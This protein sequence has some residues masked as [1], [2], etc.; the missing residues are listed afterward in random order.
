MNPH[1]FC[2]RLG[3]LGVA[4]LSL[5]FPGAGRT[6]ESE[7]LFNGK[8]LDGW[9]GLPEFWSV[10]DGVIVGETTE[11]NPTQGNTFLVW[12]GGEVA[13]FEITCQV[14]FQGNNSGL[15]YR[16]S[17]VDADK[18]VL[19]GYQADLHPKQ[20]Y[21]GMLY[22]EKLGKRGIIAQRGQRVEIGEDGKPKVV[23]EVGDGV[24]LKDWEW[25]TLRVIAVGNRLLH[26]VNGVTTV[27]IT[28]G[29]PEA[30]AKGVIGLQL[31]A[32]PPMRVEF[33]DIRLR[34]LAGD[35]A[36]AVL[37][38][39]I[40]TGKGSGKKAAA[41]NARDA[42]WLAKD[43]ELRWIWD[44]SGG[45]N[46]QELWFRKRF[47]IPAG[48]DVKS[49]RI[50]ATCDN[51]MTLWVNGEKAG[52]SRDWPYPIEIDEDAAAM[53]RPGEN[54]IAIH[55]K[56][57]G[58]TA[59][60]VFKL[61]AKLADGKTISVVSSPDWKMMPSK[62]SEGWEAVGFDDS[63]WNG[64]VVA[65]EKIGG[66]PWGIPNYT[67]QPR[68]G[69]GSGKQSP[70]PPEDIT[71][72]EGFK[73]ELLYTV[74]RDD[75]GSWVALTKLPGGKLIAS[76]QGKAGLYEI[77]L[78]E[79][80]DGPKVTV[81]KIPADVSGAWGM[82]WAFDSLYANINGKTLVRV[83]D[84]DG[85]G[86]LDAVEELPGANGGGEHGNHAV[87]PTADGKRLFV[88]AGNSTN[89]MEIAG[90]RVPTWDE[91][92]LLPRQWDARGHARG[93]LAPGGWVS[94]FDPESKDYE[95]F[96]MGF[97]NQY[98]I[99]LNRNGDLFTYDADMEWD[100]GMPWYRPT[101]ICH[102]VSGADFGW[103]S[104]SGK[105]PSYYEDS[106]P[107]VVDI[108]PG[109]PTGVV[110]G[111][112]A[113][114]PSK[115]RDAI[116]ALDWTFGTIYAIHLE[117]QGAGYTGKAEPFVYGAPL[118]VTD[119]IVGDDGALYFTI[120]GRNTQSALYRVT[121]AGEKPG[122]KA[123]AGDP[124]AAK[125]RA[126]RAELEQFHGKVAD[127]AVEKAWPFLS[128]DDRF[129][130][131]AARIAIESQPVEAWADRVFGESDSQARITGAVALARTGDPGKHRAKLLASLL[132]L[133]PDSLTEPQLLGLLRAYALNFIRLGKPTVAERERVIA[134]LD[135]L[136]PQAN[137]DVNTELVRVLVYLESPS[138]IGK[139]MDLIVNR[140]APEVPDW[141]ELASRNPGYGGKIQEM[142]QN[143][144]PSREI[145]Y[146][147]LLRNLKNGWSLKQRRDYFQFLNEAA[148]HTGGASYAG[149]LTN[150]RDEAL[151]NCTNAERAALA[152]VTGENFNPVPDF[153]IAPPKGPGRNWT[154]EDAA[155]HVNSGELKRASF[156]DGRSL[157]H[158]IGCAAC[159][160]F[161]GLGGDIGPDLTSVPN[162]FDANYVLE[163][164]IKPSEVISDQYG[165]SSVTMKN[166]DSHL[167][168]V[169]EREDTVDIY[170]PVNG[171][172]P[173]TVKA[174]DVAKIEESPVSQMPPGLINLL[175]GD[176]VRDLIAYL[177]S[178]GDPDAK[179]YGN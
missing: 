164:I 130:R 142:L 151:G 59:A 158:A 161:D 103:R 25:N 68:S 108:G 38:K 75:E 20:E 33:K 32:G 95:L 131:H 26:Q 132:E 17:I 40:A 116:F 174:A 18:F 79:S 92:L 170:P 172:E 43:G 13:D 148:K 149:F 125:A 93:R 168:L 102:V 159:H 96:A 89:L 139:T 27:D 10:T 91:D 118:P 104:G 143:H 60:L 5:A 178:G 109:S 100:M 101:R 120:G 106:L 111:I 19:A 138:V 44:E 141:T 63:A 58:G 146:A 51:Q 16:S 166:G 169:I 78:A 45:K 98:D 136:L 110:A 122:E 21:F 8:N 113:K 30:L 133:D 7:P 54:V 39:A 127:G 83:R 117:E 37:E 1:R 160:R 87:I 119:A 69:G 77:S 24:T 2:A 145:G 6:Q 3:L 171:A 9:K 121:W 28:D 114:F 105:W 31:H 48:A 123:T 167:G 94:I 62:P 86:R 71:A 140:G 147:F 163:S 56:N 55:A 177:M 152:D 82:T 52:S 179:V 12:Q 42:N 137:A 97:R 156:E 81:E 155:R 53:L 14:R 80:A 162:K 176:E 70:L 61:E 36:K 107:P 49:A 90:S 88:D 165:S 154:V 23:G 72:A 153:E 73:V 76:D 57:A 85:D 65:R 128:S 34:K 126:R 173:I 134:E 35:E 157:F 11:A 47:E 99:A 29:H 129:L 150:L 144:P 135:P 84:S 4:L 41:A 22:G 112:D 46:G 50:Y 115:Y 124:E 175:N 64:K 67:S 15:Q 74:P 66:G